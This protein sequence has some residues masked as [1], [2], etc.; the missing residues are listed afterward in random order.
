MILESLVTTKETSEKLRD[1]GFKAETCFF[2]TDNG[3]KGKF[4]VICAE[5]AEHLKE[6]QDFAKTFPKRFIPCYTF[7]QPWEALPLSIDKPSNTKLL[8]GRQW[9]AEYSIQYEKTVVN[10]NYLP[11]IAG[12]AI[13]WCIEEGYLKT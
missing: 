6:V 4:R 11:D 3:E 10:G 7:Q 8:R 2:W 1:V 5:E 13:L 12:E 9:G